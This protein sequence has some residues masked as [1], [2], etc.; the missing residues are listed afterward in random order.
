MVLPIT[1]ASVKS[2][3]AR[4]EDVRNVL[5]SGNSKTLRGLAKS[6]AQRS[7]H[8]NYRNCL[9]FRSNE[10]M[11]SAQEESA[12]HL[13]GFARTSGPPTI[14]FVF[15]GQGAQYATMAKELVLGNHTFR[16]TIRSLDKT[17]RTLPSDQ[18][19]S[20]TL[21]QTLLDSEEVSRIHDVTRSQPICTAIQIAMVDMLFNSGVVPDGGV[22]GHSSGEIAAAYAASLLTRT[23]AILVAYFR[24]YAVG[25]LQSQGAMMA[26]G[27]SVQEAETL[28][29]EKGLAGQV[30]VAC[31]N[32]SAS[33]TLS[34]TSVGIDTLVEEIQVTRKRF[35]RKLQTG[36]R[37][38][39]SYMMKEIGSLYE[40][41]ISPLF[42]QG[43]E[44]AIK[45][46]TAKFEMFSSVGQHGENPTMVGNGTRWPR[47]WR[48]NLEMPVQFV[49]ALEELAANNNKLHL[50]EIG[51]HSALKGPINQIRTH[52][53]RDER[54]LL[55]SSS[56]TRNED[57]DICMKRMFATLWVYGHGLQWQN[58]N[59]D[60]C[61]ESYVPHLSPYPWDYSAGLLWQEPRMS[62][63][64]RNRAHTR[65]ELLG[66]KNVAGDG[67]KWSW[68]NVLRLDEVPW[69]RDHRIE[70]QIVFPAA[71][72]LAVAIEALKQIRPEVEKGFS[73]DFRNVGINAALVIPDDQQGDKTEVELHTNMSPKELS[74]TT[75]S[76]DWYE[77][78]MSS[79]ASTT[80]VHCSGSVRVL[81]DSP[82]NN[83][84]ERAVAVHSAAE[85]EN[86]PTLDRWYEKFEEGGLTFGPS[87]RSVSGLKTSGERHRQEA[88]CTTPLNPLPNET[89]YPVHPVL[90][91][92]CL[93]AGIMSTTAGDLSA[94]RGFMPVFIEECQIRPTALHGPQDSAAIYARSIKTGLSTQRIDCTLLGPDGTLVVNLHQVRM[95]QY[96]AKLASEPE[97]TR[98]P[99]LRVEWKPD[100][101][102]LREDGAELLTKYLGNLFN[103]LEKAD[104]E[105][106]GSKSIPT[107]AGLLDLFG[108][109]NP[110]MRVLELDDGLTCGTKPW[111]YL[112]GADTGFQRYGSWKMG[113][114]NELGVFALDN[115]DSSESCF[116]VVVISKVGSACRYSIRQQC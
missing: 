50:I 26:A 84:L 106:A 97:M 34:G 42:R 12:V 110:R 104:V 30:C 16:A 3:D 73:F 23:Q 15:T 45:D 89:S 101:Q 79:I 1:A 52:L 102:L 8:F 7:T 95:S 56:L 68:R 78:T 62:T 108:H 70:S 10:S 76:S 114:L 24:G 75:S 74:T 65:H 80:T 81:V 28:L 22:I 18:A 105:L 57:A 39:H 59:S 116:D 43:K 83:S 72:Y 109:K 111:P 54:T 113:K 96:T 4:T 87:F 67:S 49:S 77:F 53:K 27:L 103:N 33:V 17:L 14:A 47:Y 31:V 69:L 100:I 36:G 25:K 2:L 58:I 115:L 66:S 48:N 85:F 61:L 35:A 40:E 46:S 71:A 86:W 63:E 41:L 32:S 64:I 38:Y 29:F 5:K 11:G 44:N 13:D 92:A 91:D 60:S 82:E 94:L 21:E 37:A 93:Q 90:V 6:L 51:P 112:L 98:Q 99:C 107:I 88:V 9:V 55:Y 20:W 19:P